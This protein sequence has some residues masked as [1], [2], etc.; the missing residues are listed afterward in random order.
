MFNDKNY[1]Y[2]DSSFDIVNLESKNV[3]TSNRFELPKKSN[4]LHK[5]RANERVRK[6]IKKWKRLALPPRGRPA[7]YITWSKLVEFNFA[8]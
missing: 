1:K 3:D 8:S 6:L 7:K 5:L 2:V 4:Q